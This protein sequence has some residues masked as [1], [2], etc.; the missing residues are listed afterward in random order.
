MTERAAELA[1]MAEYRRIWRNDFKK[2]SLTALMAEEERWSE[3]IAKHPH[4]LNEDAK[5]LQELLDRIEVLEANVINQ[6]RGDCPIAY[7]RPTYEQAQAM[8]A[9][10][11][12]Y[13]P[14][15]APRG[16]QGC[17]NFGG[18][19][20]NKTFG[21]LMNTILWMVPNV[22]D[23][24]IFQ[25]FEDHL[26]RGKYRIFRKPI[27]EIWHK[28]GRMVF[29]DEEPPFAGKNIWHGCP[30]DDH[31]KNK[32]DRNYRKLMP[33]KWVKR[34][35]KEYKW[36]ISEKYF[37]TIWDTRL[38]GK[39][40]GS[41]IQA[42]SGEEVIL[43]NLDEG[44]PEDKMSE[45]VMR[46]RYIQWAYTPQ[47]AA[48]IAERAAIAREVY[49]GERNLV[50]QV[51]IL[52]SK[53]LDTPDYI[54]DPD[55]KRIR[56][57]NAEKMGELGRVSL[58]GGFF[59]SS[60]TVFS[61]FNRDRH[62]LPITGADVLDAINGKPVPGHPWM[63]VF[64]DAN[65]IRGF[66]EGLAHPTAC[67]WAAVLESG[68]YVVFKEYLESNA[69]I[70]ERCEKIIALSGNER[71]PVLA[72]VSKVD[73]EAIEM[74]A[75]FAP[76]LL[77][78]R[79]REEATGQKVRRY[80]EKIGKEGMFI[81]K[82]FADSKIFRRDPQHPLDSWVEHYSREGLKMERA[83]NALPEARCDYVNGMFRADMTRQHLNP[84]QRTPENPYGYRL[85]VT[86]DC[87]LIVKKLERYLWEQFSGGPRR[88]D[89]T[90]KPDRRE[91]ELPDVL[92]YICCS[93][94]K[95]LPTA[96]LRARRAA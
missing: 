40:Y 85:Y 15:A 50:G 90:G 68:E 77:R 58:E 64:K 20:S 26:G 47:E 96:E 5:I 7:Y 13:V 49:Y 59:D 81:R 66:D 28:Q 48:N 53:T 78:D 27:W 94:T 14:E 73:Q 10:S 69:S 54:M 95:W 25:E 51:K 88:G 30:D 18:K 43:L 36:N 11:P 67:A 42:W 89:P 87:P 52:K 86:M 39:L 24:P 57:E 79:K 38:S 45:A 33:M 29:S 72:A 21:I 76:D 1:E 70:G 12:E 23:W 65:I 91:D 62:I 3:L 31:W 8:N 60:P 61:N 80:R 17:A 2:K 75:Q 71:E 37:E 83:S 63:T 41:D 74:A 82:T 34:V 19:R 92:G 84:G 93:K 55:M 32:L 35:G 44:V 46:S 22:E 9:W 6:A 56:R 4:R 16:Y